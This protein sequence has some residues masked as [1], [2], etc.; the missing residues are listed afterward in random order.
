MADTELDVS[1]IDW[2]FY[3]TRLNINGSTQR[4]RN[5]NNTKT[6]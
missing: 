6:L 2:T 1:G 5:I 4:D 3:E